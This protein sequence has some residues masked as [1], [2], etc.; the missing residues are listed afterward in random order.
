MN[1]LWYVCIE[2]I[3]YVVLFQSYILIH[4]HILIHYLILLSKFNQIIF[5]ENL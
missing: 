3:Q 4:I 5:F 1:N 2:H